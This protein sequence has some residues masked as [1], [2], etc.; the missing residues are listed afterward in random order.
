MVAQVQGCGV[1]LKE[2]NQGHLGSVGGHQLALEAPG[3]E[4]HMSTTRNKA[5]LRKSLTMRSLQLSRKSSRTLIRRLSCLGCN[6]LRWT[7]RNA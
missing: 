6:P 3:P 5:M 1:G 7:L 2:N 4:W